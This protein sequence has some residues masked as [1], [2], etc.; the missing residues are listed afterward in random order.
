[1]AGQTWIEVEEPD[2][3]VVTPLLIM[4]GQGEA[5][6]I[7]LA[8]RMNSSVLLMDDLRAR[9][10]AHRMGLRRMGTVALLGRAKLEGLIAVLRPELDAL[11]AK[12]IFISPKLRQA[13]LREV[14]EE[15]T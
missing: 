9:K 2:Q 6:A 8:Q 1:M 14:G 11:I 5:E 4:L 15:L 7:A 10:M 12:G 13:A 3:A